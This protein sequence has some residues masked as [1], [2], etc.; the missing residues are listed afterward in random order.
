MEQNT[1]NEPQI[2]KKKKASTY[3]NLR[4]IVPINIVTYSLDYRS[5]EV[6]NVSGI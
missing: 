5:Y 4:Q 6:R 2:P 3:Q 1:E